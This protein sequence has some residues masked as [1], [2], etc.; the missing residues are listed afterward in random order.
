M[1]Y[2]GIDPGLNSIAISYIDGNEYLESELFICKFPSKKEITRGKLR[3]SELMQ[4]RIKAIMAFVY[5]SLEKWKPDIIG[6][7][8]AG[9]QP[10]GA[11]GG[12]R[13]LTRIIAAITAVKCAV[14]V[15]GKEYYEPSPQELRKCLFDSAS[16]DKDSVRDRIVEIYGHVDLRDLNKSDYEHVFDSMAIAYCCKQLDKRR[17]IKLKRKFNDNIRR[18]NENGKERHKKAAKAT[19]NSLGGS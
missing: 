8:M 1:R 9:Y 16:G 13:G 11:K 12:G 5:L 17:K 3:I 7:E 18:V 19:R 4:E 14:I 2:C 10:R 15:Y 6:I